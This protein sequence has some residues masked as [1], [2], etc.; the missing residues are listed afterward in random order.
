MSLKHKNS[1]VVLTVKQDPWI[2]KSPKNSLSTSELL[3]LTMSPNEP[4]QKYHFVFNYIFKFSP[5]K[6]LH[7]SSHN[8][9]LP[10]SLYLPWDS[11][12]YQFQLNYQPLTIHPLNNDQ[13]YLKI[14]L[15][16][17]CISFLFTYKQQ[18]LINLH[19]SYI[20]NSSLNRW[21]LP[22]Q[23]YSLLPSHHWMAL[24]G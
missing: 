15:K 5:Y 13:I 23:P 22:G 2:E 12:S 17:S 19:R 18:S 24:C 16:Y 9:G 21:L 20:T 4:T 11:I 14:N 1:L 6:K 3:S 7:L 10:Q 8:L